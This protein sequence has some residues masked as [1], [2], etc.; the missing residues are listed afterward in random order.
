MLEEFIFLQ[1]TYPPG[2]Q[3]QLTGEEERYATVIGYRIYSG[4]AYLETLECGLINS[5]R[6][7]EMAG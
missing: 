2:T 6:V 3:V 5:R 7:K 1:N 4:S